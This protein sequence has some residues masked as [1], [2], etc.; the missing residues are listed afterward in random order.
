MSML[1]SSIST[2]YPV[3]SPMILKSAGAI[4]PG[5]ELSE[6]ATLPFPFLAESEEVLDETAFSG[7]SGSGVVT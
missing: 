7:K 4:S 3:F 2:G 1:S 5:T 6:A